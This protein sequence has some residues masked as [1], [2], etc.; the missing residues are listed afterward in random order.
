[1]SPAEP[2]PGLADPRRLALGLDA[3]GDHPEV[4]H[5]GEA[6]RARDDDAVERLLTPGRPER[7]LAV[8]P[9]A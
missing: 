3:L 4:A 7:S 8:S 6:G 1:M 2:A 5:P 9:S